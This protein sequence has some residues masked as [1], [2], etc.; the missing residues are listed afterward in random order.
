M[1]TLCCACKTVDLKILRCGCLETYEY[2]YNE[3][4]LLKLEDYTIVQTPVQ[5]LR[6]HI[7]VTRLPDLA[8]HDYAKFHYPTY[9]TRIIITK[10]W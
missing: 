4:F 1:K 9:G 6:A 10:L 5:I 3:L 8:V 7:S 2:T